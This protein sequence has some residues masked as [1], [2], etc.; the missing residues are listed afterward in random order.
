MGG[1][2]LFAEGQLFSKEKTPVIMIMITVCSCI[3]K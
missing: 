3:I 1:G 2:E